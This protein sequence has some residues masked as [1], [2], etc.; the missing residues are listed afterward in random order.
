MTTYGTT[1]ALI[2]VQIYL[3]HTS[4]FASRIHTAYKKVPTNFPKKKTL[5]VALINHNY[6]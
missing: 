3:N 1:Q 5:E 2:Q 6:L 4:T